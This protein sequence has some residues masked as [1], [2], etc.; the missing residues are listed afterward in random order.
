MR[1]KSNAKQIELLFFAYPSSLKNYAGGFL[2]MKKVADL[3]DKSGCYTV[4][5][6]DN[7]YSAKK[8]LGKII[9]DTYIALTGFAKCPDVVILDSWG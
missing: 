7:H 5:T 8:Y 6:I 3:I 1:I 9:A 4:L 2:W